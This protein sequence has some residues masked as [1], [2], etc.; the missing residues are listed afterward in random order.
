MLSKTLKDGLNQAVSA[1]VYHTRSSLSHPASDLEIVFVL[2][3]DLEIRSEEGVRRLKDPDILILN[4]PPPFFQLITTPIRMS[5]LRGCYF[6]LL[7]LDTAFLS[8]VFNGN[9]PLFNCDSRNQQKD[10]G[11]LRSILAE[12]ASTD[13]AGQDKNFLFFSRIFTLLSELASNFTIPGEEEKTEAGEEGRRLREIRSYLKKH[14]RSPLTL[15]ELA[16]KFSLSPQYMS[17]YFK[18]NFG[19][20]FHTYINRLRL[21]SAL[22]DL[23]ATDKPV[24]SIAYDNGFPNLNSFT[25]EMKT[26]LGQTPTTYRKASRLRTVAPAEEKGNIVDPVKVKDKLSPYIT[27]KHGQAGIVKK[28][29][30]NTR[31]GKPLEKPWQECINLGFAPDFEKAEFTDQVTLIQNEAPFRYARFQGIFGRSM[32]G[33]EGT[34]YSFTR[35]DRLI[36]FLYSVQLLPFI[37]LGFKPDKISRGPDSFVFNDNDELINISLEDYERI[38]TGFLKHEINRYGTQEISRWRFEFW[39]PTDE[40]AYYHNEEI[41]MYIEWFI[42]IRKII[43]KIVPSAL[44][45]GP[46]LNICRE[47]SLDTLGK[48]LAR[49]TSTESYPDFISL[50]LFCFSDPSSESTGKDFGLTLWA[51]DEIPKKIAWIKDYVKSRDLIPADFNASSFFV[52]EWNIDH[53]GRNM[54]HDFL[55]T[56]P[57]ILQNAIDTIDQIG[58]LSYWLAS[59]ISAEYSDSDALLFG[60]AGLISRHKIRKPGFFAY[61]FLSRLGGKLLAKGEGYI[62]TA[63]SENEYVGIIFN[64]KY[65]NLQ[66]R[67]RDD[68]WRLAGNVQDLMEDTNNAVFSITLNNIQGG[69]YKV[70]QHIMNT[71][72]GSVYDTWKKL[73]PNGEILE[74]EAAWLERTCEPDLHI[75]FISCSNTF[76]FECELE[77]NEVRLLEISL[78]LE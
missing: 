48:I 18:K 23:A 10:F 29:S 33:P 14:C 35:I 28:L 55:F 17:R 75:D 53:S 6:L 22:K 5:S 57:F 46:G 37:E 45:G 25:Q 12:I 9:I 61:Q 16:R 64:Y 2:D 1:L 3:G 50:Y 68:F 20:N 34:D 65:I 30:I 21:E 26:E 62:I 43:K 44:L 78:M 42:R 47:S 31:E 32:I 69:R 40:L 38:I 36:N 15:D 74:S 63:K 8:L 7:R 59:D 51:K 70:R 54:I 67:F 56:A 49:L 27:K 60:G 77:P 71:L 58:I 11:P 39:A 41:E 19:C 66:F 13:T 52:T 24:T 72:H 76:S 4:P 73:S